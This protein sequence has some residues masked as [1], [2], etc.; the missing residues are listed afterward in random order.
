MTCAIVPEKT[1][2]QIK[3]S[4][5]FMKTN[6]PFLKRK[7]FLGHMQTVKMM[8]MIMICCFNILSYSKFYYQHYE[9]VSKF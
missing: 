5:F 9:L 1:G 2:V 7:L 4:Y 8:M 6:E 3:L